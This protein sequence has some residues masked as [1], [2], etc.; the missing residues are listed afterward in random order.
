MV[1]CE[2]RAAASGALA[3][4]VAATASCM[5]AAICWPLQ[6]A[7]AQLGISAP[8]LPGVLLFDTIASRTA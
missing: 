2:R 5:P 7:Q 3:P 8:P 1:G 6:S 4:L